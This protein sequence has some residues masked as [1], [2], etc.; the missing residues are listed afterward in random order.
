MKITRKIL[1]AL[2][3]FLYL[4]ASES[5]FAL[6]DFSQEISLLTDINNYNSI[7]CRTIITR[8]LFAQELISKEGEKAFPLIRE[9]NNKL[10]DNMYIIVISTNGYTKVHQDPTEENKNRIDLTDSAGTP[11]VKYFIE[12]ARENN[13]GWIHYQWEVQNSFSS[14]WKTSFVLPARSPEGETYVVICGGFDIPVERLFIVDM[15][16]DFCQEFEKKGSICFTNFRDKTTKIIN[17][18]TYIYIISSDG[19]ELFNP[20]FPVMEGRNLYNY[21]DV[22]GQFIVRMMLNAVKDK[23]KAWVKYMWKNPDTGKVQTK[24]TY[25]RKIK[26]GKKFIVMGAGYFSTP[27]DM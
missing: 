18:Q 20:M 9:F 21:R 8:I 1:I 25:L 22:S 12:E 27:N 24:E 4:F 13:G 10:K 7:K 2:F 19:V 16:N 5:I 14:E 15:V 26:Y 23:D 6:K 17:N 11:F 3:T